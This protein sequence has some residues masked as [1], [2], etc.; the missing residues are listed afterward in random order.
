MDK[1][2]VQQIVRD[3]PGICAEGKANLLS[4]I[5]A[6][7]GEEITKTPPKI[8]STHFM[9]QRSA[10][11]GVDIKY[12]D[13]FVIHFNEDGSFF[14]QAGIPSILGFSLDSANRIQETRDPG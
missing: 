14:R 8:E 11:G 5:S 3:M 7:T 13:W 4:L 2:K 10:R 9:L 6:I 12:K 1:E